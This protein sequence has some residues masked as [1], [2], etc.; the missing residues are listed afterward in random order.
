MI[1]KSGPTLRLS[2]L[3]LSLPLCP[4]VSQDQP[5]RTRIR[6]LSTNPSSFLGHEWPAILLILGVWLL[7]SP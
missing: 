7:L 5:G 2:S 3:P 6:V 4:F 1:L